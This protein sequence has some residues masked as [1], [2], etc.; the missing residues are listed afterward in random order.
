MNKLL[1]H[2]YRTLRIGL[3]CMLAWSHNLMSAE[4]FK[5]IQRAIPNAELVG[6]ARMSYLFWDIYDAA[7][8]APNGKWTEDTPYALTLTYLRDLKGKDIAKRSIEEMQK[9]GFIDQQKLDNWLILMEELF[10]DVN[11]QTVLIGIADKQNHSH[12]F[13]HDTYLG[14]VDD[15]A[16]T[17]EFFGIWLHP[18]TSEPELRRQLLGTT[19]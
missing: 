13:L 8:F 5:P 14:S 7:L 16:F 15:P 4:Q 1:L 18:G 17:A 12:F 19:P 10:P 2:F 3:L 6:E 9:Q 11:D